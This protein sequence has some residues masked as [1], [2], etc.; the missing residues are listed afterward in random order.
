MIRYCSLFYTTKAL[1]FI[2]TS[3]ELL[4]KE[5]EVNILP[6]RTLVHNVG[7]GIAGI[8][9]GVRGRGGG[10]KKRTKQEEK[11]K[12]NITQKVQIII[13]VEYIPLLPDG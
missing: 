4:N 9:K 8:S 12:D 6:N 5:T 1:S 10:G 7:W 11:E 2:G 13:L 3:C